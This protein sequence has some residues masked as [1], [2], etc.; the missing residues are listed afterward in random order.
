VVI[1]TGITIRIEN[2]PVIGDLIVGR[3][4]P[5]NGSD[6]LARCPSEATLYAKFTVLVTSSG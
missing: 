5:F 2:S 4:E 1:V 3:F 6:T